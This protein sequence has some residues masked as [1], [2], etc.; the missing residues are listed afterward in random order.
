MSPGKKSRRRGIFIA[1]EGI[2]GAGTT[3]QTEEIARWLNGEGI[4]TI[5]T[6]EPTIGE[7]GRPIRNMLARKEPLSSNN[8]ALLFAADRMIHYE[9]EIKRHIDEGRWV[10]SDRYRLSSLAYQGIECDL[11]WVR[12]INR[13]APPADLTILID[14]PVKTA[15]KRIKSRGL[16]RE[17]FESPKKLE[18]V[19]KLYLDL[20]R[21][22]DE[23]RVVI[24]DGSPPERE[25]LTNIKEV[26]TG[27]LKKP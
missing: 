10:I 24:I 14:L 21:R 17:R 4:K 2:D 22:R 5:S 20:A 3:T 15:L 6:F 11:K 23:G 25:V 1:I 13:Y 8:L 7:I 9:H 16:A 27:L 18:K 26:I 19:R 12:S